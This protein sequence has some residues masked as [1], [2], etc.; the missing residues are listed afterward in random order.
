MEPNTHGPIIPWIDLLGAYDENGKRIALLFSHAAHP[1]IIHATSRLIS[2]DFPGLAI[3]RLQKRFSGGQGRAEGVFMFAQGCGGDI[4]GH[5][6]LGGIEACQAVAGEIE[7]SVARTAVRPLTPGMIRT[8]KVELQL[9]FQDPPTKEQC[10]KWISQ[11][12]ADGRFGELLKFVERGK[13]GTLRYPISGFS[14]GDELAII[15]LAHE[16]VCSYQLFTVDASPFAHTMVFGYNHGVEQ[17]I[18]TAADY[19]LGHLG[20]YEAAPHGHALSSKHRLALSPAA[21]AMIHEG[22]ARVL[23]QLQQI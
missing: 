14:V 23:S 13:I 19:E 7:R 15:G 2:G 4:N 10:K 21:E 16:P 11:R 8:A 17:Y 3:A 1:V 12:P 6:L 22:I 18:A 20:G 9:P 5:P